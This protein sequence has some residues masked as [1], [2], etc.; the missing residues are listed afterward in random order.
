MSN[1]VEWEQG[2]E[3]VH[4][5]LL[6]GHL[7]EMRERAQARLRETR[8]SRGSTHQ[9]MSERDSMS[10]LLADQIER[11]DAVENGLCFG[12]IDGFDGTT[13]YIGR[14]GLYDEK[15]GEHIPLLTDWRAP[16][17]RPFYL[18]TAASPEGVQRR[19]HIRTRGR[20]VTDLD[21]EVLDLDVANVTAGK[22]LSG[23]AGEAT[24]M[25]AIKAKRTGRMSDIVETIQAE[26]DVVIR[27]DLGGALVV[28]GGPGTG[29]T[30]VALH[31]A[32][33][34]LYTFRELLETRAV[35]IVG[36]NDT[37]LRYISQVLPSLAE[38]GVLLCT[39]GDLF[40]GVTARREEPA[41]VA[42]IKGRLTFTDI[43]RKALDDRQ[44]QPTKRIPIEIDRD[45][46][47][48]TLYLEPGEARRARNLARATKK[49]HNAARAAFEKEIVEALTTKIAERIGDDPFADITRAAFESGRKDDFANAED[50]GN[51]VLDQSDIAEIRKSLAKEP[52]VLAVCDWLWPVLTPQQLVAG[53]YA[54]PERLDKAAPQLTGSE[55]AALRRDPRGGWTAADVPLLDEAAELLDGDKPVS[56]EFV[57]EERE[58][59]ARR[60]YAEG[61]LQILEGSR[62]LDDEEDP[63]YL[64]ATDLIDAADLGERQRV[65]SHVTAAQRAAADR[66]WAFGHIIVDEAQELSPMAWRLLM[67]RCPSRSLTLVGDVAQTGDL[68]GAASWETTLR[69]YVENRWRLAELTVNY[70][71]PAEIMAVAAGVLAD[72]DPTMSPP[73]S[74][75]ETGVPPWAE[76]ID[77]VKLTDRLVDAVRQETAEA[78]DGRVGVLVPAG[79]VADLGAAV[80]SAIGGTAVGAGADLVSPVVVLTVKQAKGL[81]FDSVLLVEPDE[82]VKGSPRGASDLY[83]ALTRATQRLGIL[84][85]KPLPPAVRL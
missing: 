11:Y 9:A 22:T 47:R 33:Y 42:E 55:R 18:A 62:S 31:R 25:A 68:S 46:N 59:L 44:R 24:L 30:A 71:T 15:S 69:P 19:R 6:Y 82:I 57:I 32:A 65:R 27:S 84:H 77:P 14:I 66:S 39:V 61:A 41:V 40:P 74:V 83:V 29:K 12:R 72:I 5:D 35:L 48:E 37:F 7:D 79:R 8:L 63:E 45:G 2:Q 78:G 50:I 53:L 60:E 75:R 17:S 52:E 67:R 23:L 56:D 26:Q 36:P 51:N 80:A 64:A 38:T 34:L 3:Q 73:R 81:E 70:R 49:P 16:A 43:L 10:A 4:L 58:R 85:T 28:Q 1:D 13:R 76:R 21:D 20:K 54:S